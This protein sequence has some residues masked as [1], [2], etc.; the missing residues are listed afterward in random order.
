[1]Q[2]ISIEGEPREP[3]T[4]VAERAGVHLET[5]CNTGSCGICEVEVRKFQETGVPSSVEAPAVVRACITKVPPG[6]SRIEISQL[7]DSIWGSDGWDT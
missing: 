7:S 3:L 1:M 2:D 6:Y 5:G 4:Q